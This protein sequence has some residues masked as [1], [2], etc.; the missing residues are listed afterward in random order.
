MIKAVIF[1]MDGLMINS[2]EL[3]ARSALVLFK[4]L[5]VDVN[6]Y[7]DKLPYVPGTRE[8]DNW[9]RFV[10][11]YDLKQDILT[12]MK[13]RNKVYLDML[14][15]NLVPMKGIL[16]LINLLNEK[17]MRMAVAS[18]STMEQIMFVV[19]HLKIKKYFDVI[20]TGHDLE[21]GKPFPDVFL[22]TA[23]KLDEKP[24]NCLVLEDS[25]PGVESAKAAGMK[26]IAIP[27]EH[28][29]DHDFSKADMVMKSA[30]ELDWQTIS[31]L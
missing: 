16:E 29:K 12:L 20:V 4:Q 22:D 7:K 19:E 10:K 2:E 23:Q 26:V 28:T 15:D 24:E 1:D 21:K 8:V 13:M 9:P 25:N 27:N 3:Q 17:K 11:I 6:P 5:G 31:S 18:S 14:R 30:D